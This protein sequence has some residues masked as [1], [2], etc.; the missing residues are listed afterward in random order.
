MPNRGECDADLEHAG[1]IFS[2]LHEKLEDVAEV[3][4]AVKLSAFV[5]VPFQPVEHLK[6]Y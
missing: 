5:L 3:C 4:L 6:E 1:V 2:V